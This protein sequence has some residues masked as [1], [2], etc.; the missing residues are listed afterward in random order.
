MSVN[1]FIS[2][3]DIVNRVAVEVGL[4]KQSDV[5]AST[6]PAF[7]QLTGLLTACVQ[8]LMEVYEWQVLTRSHTITTS[9]SDSGRYTLPADFGYMIPQTGWEQNENVPLLGPLSAQDWTYLLGRNLVSST[10][11]ASFRYFEGT[12]NVFPNDPVPD[13]IVITFEYISRNLIQVTGT[14]PVTYSDEAEQPG[15]LVLFPPHMIT[16]MLKMYF[17][18]AKGF[19]STKAT[20]DFEKSIRSWQGKDNSAPILRASGA[21]KYPYLDGRNIPYSGFGNA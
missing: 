17:L 1:R 5:F 7:A 4:T 10:I 15:D 14:D 3:N 12:F 19:D 20:S 2:I 18:D 13:G 16:R 6:D 9:G 11:Y 21:G 8:E